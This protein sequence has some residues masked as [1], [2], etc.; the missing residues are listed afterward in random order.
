ML[1]RSTVG[2]WSWWLRFGIL[3]QLEVGGGVREF[4]NVG[5]VRQKI[6]GHGLVSVVSTVLFQI[7]HAI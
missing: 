4:L 1:S 3:E 6:I 7:S 5:L 2:C